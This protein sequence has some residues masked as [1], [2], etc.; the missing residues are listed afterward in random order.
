MVSICLT[1]KEHHARAG[2]A[3][4][5]SENPT[6]LFLLKVLFWLALTI[7]LKSRHCR[8]PLFPDEKVKAWKDS[9]WL[10]NITQLTQKQDQHASPGRLTLSAQA[11][12]RTVHLPLSGV[13]SRPQCTGQRQVEGKGDGGSYILFPSAQQVQAITWA[14]QRAAQSEHRTSLRQSFGKFGVG[15]HNLLKGKS[16]CRGLNLYFGSC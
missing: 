5:S 16:G 9:S 4:N 10:P 3:V 8:D 1:L 12:A 6:K 13:M 2:T 11:G 15:S 7:F 14:A